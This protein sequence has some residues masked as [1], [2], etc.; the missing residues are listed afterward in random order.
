MESKVN[1]LY[2]K[3]I[4]RIETCINADIKP[5]IAKILCNL[6]F[7]LKAKKTAIQKQLK[8]IMPANSN[9]SNNINSS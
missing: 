6:N 1:I 8:A 9:I 2:F 7:F 4:K 3:N 5:A